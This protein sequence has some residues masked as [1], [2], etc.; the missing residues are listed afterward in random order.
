MNKR[1]IWEKVIG[2]LRSE[3]SR[4]KLLTWFKGSAI[5]GASEEAVTIG[6]PTAMAERQ[7]A[8]Q[9]DGVIRKCVQKILPGVETVAYRVDPKLEFKEDGRA[10]DFEVLKGEEEVPKKRK[11]PKKAEV[12]VDGIRSVMI[13]ARYTLDNFVVGPDNRLAHAAACAVS[14]EPGR[15]YNPLFIYGGVGMGKTHLLQGTGNAIERKHG[16]K[17][18]IYETSETFMNEFIGFVRKQKA[19]KFKEKYRKADVLLIDDIQFFKGKESTQEEFFHTFNAL[20]MAGKQIVLTAD[21]PPKE[22]DG[23]DDRLISRFEQGM[24]VDVQFPDL[25]TRMAILQEKCHEKGVMIDPDVLEF[26][27]E[28]VSESVREL[29]GVLMQAIAES[30]LEKSSPTVR[31]VSKH[32]KKVNKKKEIVGVREMDE[33]EG[34]GKV[35]NLKDLLERVAV[36]FELKKEDLVGASRKAKIALPRQMAMYLAREKMGYTLEEVGDFFGG[37]DHTTVLHSVKRIEEG[38]K[39]DK[40]LLRDLNALRKEVRL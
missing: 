7:L 27:A 23:L 33:M 22:L 25:E 3:I 29:E 16:G 34:Q 13:D 4:A 9:F 14:N 39:T 17:V 19:D 32:L 37:R 36:F 10:I 15:N 11:M 30:E 1:E 40:R 5:I 35:C 28:N 38:R 26:I 2:E 6:V 18:V 24:V 20:Y 8:G 31:S 21:R 12:K